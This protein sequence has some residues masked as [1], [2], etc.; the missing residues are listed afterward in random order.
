MPCSQ[1][2]RRP[3]VKRVVL[4]EK[5]IF[6]AIDMKQ[7][8]I[9]NF[10]DHDV[11]SSLA[12]ELA[13]SHGQS[14]PVGSKVRKGLRGAFPKR[15]YK[16]IPLENAPSQTALSLPVSQRLGKEHVAAPFELLIVSG[17]ESFTK[18]RPPARLLKDADTTWNPLDHGPINDPGSTQADLNSDTLG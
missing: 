13:A 15:R 14:L 2:R 4:P 7:S 18:R 5:R 8:L 3:R 6:V 11:R 9:R 12:I 10:V 17:I 1:F 16:T